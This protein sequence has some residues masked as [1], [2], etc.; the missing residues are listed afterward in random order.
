LMKEPSA[1]VLEFAEDILTA[2]G[3]IIVAPEYNGGYPASLKN[4]I[5]LLYAE[6]KR[7]PVAIAAVSDGV[8]GGSQVLT[9]L[10]FTMWKIGVLLVPAM[11]RV[12]KVRENYDEQGNATDKATTDKF[13]KSFLSE[14]LWCMEAKGKMGNEI[15]V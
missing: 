8:Y 15:K 14:L 13:A 1:E 5:D 2:D 7:K 3:V 4:A 9:S 6:W 12:G 10:V 11:F